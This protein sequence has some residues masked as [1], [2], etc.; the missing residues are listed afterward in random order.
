MRAL[1]KQIME[2]GE[3]SVANASMVDMQQVICPAHGC[4]SLVFPA[5]SLF[6]TN[7]FGFVKT[8]YYKTNC[9]VQ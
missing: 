1:E 9:S 8:D 7:A 4:P 6:N 2:S 3:A 5:I